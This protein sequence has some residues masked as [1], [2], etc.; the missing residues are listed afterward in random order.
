MC[1]VHK[2]GLRSIK[3]VKLDHM[4]GQ[5]ASYPKVQHNGCSL[6]GLNGIGEQEYSPLRITTWLFLINVSYKLYV[7]GTVL[8]FIYKRSSTE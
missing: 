8:F 7:E 3:F 1:K 4:H 2:I 5:W 6:R